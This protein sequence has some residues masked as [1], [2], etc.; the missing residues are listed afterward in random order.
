MKAK[1]LGRKPRKK[2]DDLLKSNKMRVSYKAA[3]SC[4][5]LLEW[6][7]DDEVR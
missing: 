7:F 5:S 6:G 1:K 3:V 2:L 4:R